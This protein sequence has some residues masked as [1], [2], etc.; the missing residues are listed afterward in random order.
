M[1]TPAEELFAKYKE[2]NKQDKVKCWVL[3][4]QLTKQEFQKFI[5]LVEKEEE[6]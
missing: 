6:T 2:A 4:T 5:D 3:A 1:A